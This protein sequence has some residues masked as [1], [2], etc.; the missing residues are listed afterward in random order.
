MLLTCLLLFLSA[1]LMS[2]QAAARLLPRQ[3]QVPLWGACNF[4]S[5]GINGP[6]PC[7]SGSECICKDDS[8]C[9]GPLS[10]PCMETLTGELSA[11]SQCREEV[12]NSWAA[13]PSW[14]CQ[15]PGDQPTGTMP[16]T[17]SAPAQ[18]VVAAAA[19][20]PVAAVSNPGLPSDAGNDPSTMPGQVP[21]SGGAGTQP[22]AQGNCNST[23]APSG[24]DG[25]AS[26][27]VSSS[28]TVSNVFS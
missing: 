22:A 17:D 10:Y 16:S 25:V 21:S 12:D 11:Y 1:R 24:W 14:Q 5:Q 9:M 26:T 20:S 15:Q 23:S 18:P 7:A 3:G 6:L 13:D 4:P 28:S 27:S 2:V 8:T 19:S